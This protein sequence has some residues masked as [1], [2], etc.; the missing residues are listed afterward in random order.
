MS[1]PI[2]PRVDI[3]HVHLKVADL[4][5]AVAFYS[6]VLGFAVTTRM[7]NQAA[8]LSAGGY[9]HHIGLNTWESRNGQ[10]PPP[11]TTG[12]YHFAIR[13]PDRATL[14]DALRRLVEAR[15]PLEGA[16]DHGVSE[17]LYLHDPD[18]NGLELYFDRPRAQW[19]KAADGSVR[20]TTEPL[21][22]DALLE[23]ARRPKPAATSAV[24]APID[25]DARAR[26]T[27]L[28]SRLLALH[29]ALLDD[30][31]AAYE[32]DR[33][34]VASAGALLQ[35]VIHDPWFAWLHQISELVVRI[36]EMTAADAKATEA[37]AKA[38]LD[39]VDRLLLPSETGDTFARRYYEAIQRQ[40]A[41][42]LAHGAVKRLMK[43][44][45]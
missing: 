35:L 16:S 44:S 23:E 3:G 43:T 20:M 5:R 12:L 26:L 11:G 42:V 7:G 40:P 9:H 22:V 34:R 10:P 38:L 4:D 8:F 2:D 6:G 31:K 1:D 37:D 13:Y 32:M 45:A 36:D 17:A 27:E 30:A 15:I 29:K 21:D 25:A 33:G 14:A 19:P 39:Q 18:G 24:A 28:R 41:V